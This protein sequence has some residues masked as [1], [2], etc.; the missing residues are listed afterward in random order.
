M[1]QKKLDPV[2][3]AKL[4]FTNLIQR[5]VSQALHAL[6]AN[7]QE[8]D[9]FTECLKIIAMV[10]LLNEHADLKWPDLCKLEGTAVVALSY[11][12]LTAVSGF[13]FFAGY[14][15]M[16]LQTNKAF[17]AKADEAKF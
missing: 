11:Q 8:R 3:C 9:Y 13:N 12:E 16:K 15:K 1:L 6:N 7:Q 2:L 5:M 10:A 17:K 14:L 4:L